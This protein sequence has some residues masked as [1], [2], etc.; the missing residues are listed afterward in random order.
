MSTEPTRFT[1]ALAALMP[2]GFAWPRQADTVWMRVLGGLAGAFEEHH[3]WT[4]QA[5]LEWLPHATHT[6]LEEWE[7]ATGL[8]DPC[9]GPTQTMEA[10]RGRLLAR[11]RGP[12]GAYPD[13][14][15]AAIEA[16]KTICANL[17]YVADVHYNTY[18]RVGRDRVGRRLGAND[19]HL[20]VLISAPAEPFRVGANRVG[21]RLV[22]RPPS[23]PEFACALEK[24]VPARYALDVIFV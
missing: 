2:P 4:Q 18:F 9:F 20:Y 10:R 24:Y 1:Q 6:R 15:P 14:S 12:S 13:S 8:P 16:I 5:T 19:G 23:V 22:I 3:S 11:L 17:G 21:E 7:E